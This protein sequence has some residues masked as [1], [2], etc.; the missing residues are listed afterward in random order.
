[1]QGSWIGLVKFTRSLE[2]PHTMLPVHTLNVMW[3]MAVQH[4]AG[5]S[6]S[7]GSQKAVKAG[8]QKA[9][10]LHSR[11]ELSTSQGS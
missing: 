6:T 4:N 8:S 10:K 2:K 5:L 11:P 3:C 1:M 9:Q 7:L